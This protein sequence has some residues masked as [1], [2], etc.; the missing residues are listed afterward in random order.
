MNHWTVRMPTPGTVEYE[1]ARPL[2]ETVGAYR[3]RPFRSAPEFHEASNDMQKWI[4][5]AGRPRIRGAIDRVDREIEADF[6]S[7]PD[8]LR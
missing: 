7:I 1:A 8:Q 2:V 4:E 3:N 5:I 6:T